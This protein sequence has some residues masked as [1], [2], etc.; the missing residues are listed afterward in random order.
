MV[1]M[2]AGV[3]GRMESIGRMAELRVIRAAGLSA[4]ALRAFGRDDRVLGSIEGLVLSGGSA[5]GGSCGHG[6]D[7]L[8]FE[9]VEGFVGGSPADFAE[10][11]GC[12]FEDGFVEVADVVVEP[13]GGGRMRGDG[14]GLEAEVSVVG[15]DLFVDGRVMDGDGWDGRGHGDAGAAD[16][17]ELE[18]AALQIVVGGGVLGDVAGGDEEDAGVVERER[19]RGVVRDDDAD[20]HEAVAEVVEA[21]VG[22]GVFAV[23]GVGGDGDVLVGMGVVAGILGSGERRPG[24]AR[25][26][27]ARGECERENQR[28]R[29]GVESGAAR[30]TGWIILLTMRRGQ[31]RRTSVVRE[32]LRGRAR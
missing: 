29:C 2:S 27:G 5:G 20:G 28:E 24:F 1:G 9:A 32:L 19:L 18:E 7:Q 26:V 17:L 13:A 15:E 14:G 21:G 23:A 6:G 8:D 22:R 11:E 25:L 16:G 30:H 31:K 3:A 12:S 10:L 4:S